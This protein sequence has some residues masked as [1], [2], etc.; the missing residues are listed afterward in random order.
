MPHLAAFKGG[1][2]RVTVGDCGRRRDL[3][4]VIPT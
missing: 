4:M 3:E 2:V 1:I